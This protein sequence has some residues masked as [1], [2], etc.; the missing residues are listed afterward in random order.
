MLSQREPEA[1]DVNVLQAVGTVNLR[2]APLAHRLIQEVIYLGPRQST[3]HRTQHV[4]KETL[5][6][7]SRGS[8]TEYSSLS[9]FT[10]YVVFLYITM[11]AKS[12]QNSPQI[13][14]SSSANIPCRFCPVL[15]LL[16]LPLPPAGSVL[17]TPLFL[18]TPTVL[19]TP[20]A[21]ELTLRIGRGR[22]SPDKARI[23]HSRY[24]ESAATLGAQRST[25]HWL[26]LQGPFILQ[27][28]RSRRLSSLC[29]AS[30]T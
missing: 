28:T 18:A 25:L 19:A 8:I 7:G 27:I 13:F 23:P 16:A 22:N 15:W 1:E 29:V 10:S 17:A 11:K 24:I 14:F 6:C 21:L 12:R 4:R 30:Y 9:C 2:E 20:P 5:T 26:A 3:W